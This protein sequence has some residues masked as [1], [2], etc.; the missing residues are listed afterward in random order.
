[1][2]TEILDLLQKDA[3]IVLL[4]GTRPGCTTEFYQ[5]VSIEGKMRENLR[6]FEYPKCAWVCFVER[7]GNEEKA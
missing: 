5:L 3:R 4:S 6:F 1:V 2:F 7:S